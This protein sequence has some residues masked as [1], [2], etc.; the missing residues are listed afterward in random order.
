MILQENEADCQLGTS[1]AV[2]HGL[3]VCMYLTPTVFFSSHAAA[4][5]LPHS[6]IR[7][8]EST[9]FFTYFIVLVPNMVFTCF[10]VMEQCIICLFCVWPPSSSAAK[11][12]HNYFVV[13]SLH[14]CMF[15]ELMCDCTMKEHQ[16]QSD[17]DTENNPQFKI[18]TPPTI[19][20]IVGLP[21]TDS[22]LWC[23]LLRLVSHRAMLLINWSVF[24]WTM[25]L[26]SSHDIWFET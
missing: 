6:P 2:N 7:V 22:T 20:N 1:A 12:L 9:S 14:S 16:T 18:F 21:D 3:Y 25:N 19:T 26:T 13:L 17:S 4:N 8:I 24:L 15:P 11:S 10:F 5:W 23:S